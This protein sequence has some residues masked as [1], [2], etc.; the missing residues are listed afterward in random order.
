MADLGLV[1]GPD[2][3]G[4]IGNAA[5][6]IERGD[7]IGVVPVARRAGEGGLDIGPD[8]VQQHQGLGPVGRFAGGVVGADGADDDHRRKAEPEQ[9]PE[10]AETTPEPARPVA[11]DGGRHARHSR[12]HLCR[13]LSSFHRCSLSSTCRCHGC[14]RS[15]PV[16]RDRDACGERHAFPPWFVCPWS[17][18]MTARPVAAP[19]TSRRC[20]PPWPASRRSGG[21]RSAQPRGT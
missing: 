1:A 7:Q 8:P 17:S 9:H 21:R 16:R 18:L 10:Q 5:P 14:P 12:F 11:F 13:H 20:R 2:R 6:A 15:R 4:A 19:K 3:P